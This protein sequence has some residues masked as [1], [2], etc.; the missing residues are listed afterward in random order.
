MLQMEGSSATIIDFG[1]GNPAD[2][3]IITLQP[4]FLIVTGQLWPLSYPISPVTLTS[5]QWQFLAFT[6]NRTLLSIY[7]DGLLVINETH[8]INLASIERIN[9]YI[10]QSSDPN[11]GY[12]YSLLDDLRFYNV[13]LT[14]SQINVLQKEASLL[15]CDTTSNAY[16]ATSGEFTVFGELRKLFF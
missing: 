2:N 13:S 15:T 10:G 11:N 3:I 5:N 12:S 4:S 9:N 6:F 14:Q 16:E 1:N 7:L 8:K